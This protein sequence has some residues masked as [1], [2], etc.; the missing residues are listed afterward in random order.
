MKKKFYALCLVLLLLWIPTGAMAEEFIHTLPNKCTAFLVGN[1]LTGDIL[2][3]HNTDDLLQIASISKLLTYY[4][5][6]DA[7]AKGDLTLETRTTVSKH[8]ADVGGSS[9]YLKEGDKVNVQELLDGMM[10][11]SGNDA[12]TVLEIRKIEY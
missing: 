7:I 3:S 10:I 12:A 4:I 5:T 1:P 8:A 6:K 2:A 9:M 11:I